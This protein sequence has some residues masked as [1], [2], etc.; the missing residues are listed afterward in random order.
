M[1]LRTTCHVDTETELSEFL[2]Q[3]PKPS[4]VSQTI[5]ELRRCVKQYEDRYGIESCCLHQAIDDGTLVE[6]REVGRWIFQY[7]LLLRAE[8][9]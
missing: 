8:A 5:S 2:T 7:N 4:D 3:R 1:G 6:D 9:E